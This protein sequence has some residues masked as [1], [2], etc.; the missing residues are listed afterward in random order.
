MRET[1]GFYYCPKRSDRIIY[2][3]KSESLRLRILLMRVHVGVIVRK[4]CQESKV[5]CGPR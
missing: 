2:G 3:T 5:E 1:G 4:T